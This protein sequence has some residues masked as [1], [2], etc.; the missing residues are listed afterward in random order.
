VRYNKLTERA[1]RVSARALALT[2]VVG[3]G[4]SMLLAVTLPTAA[5][6]SPV[7]ATTNSIHKACSAAVTANEAQCLALINASIPQV[8]YA[9]RG[10]SVP[11][12][13]P[14]SLLKAY[15]LAQ[16]ARKRGKG[17]VV[18]VVD[19]FNDPKAAHDLN[20]Y[21]S[22]FNLPKCTTSN[23]CFRKVNQQ[24]KAHPLPHNAGST[25]WDVEESLDIDMVS[26]VCPHCRIVLVETW[27]NNNI[28]LAKGVD[29][30]IKAGA[31]FI[32]NSYQ[33]GQSSSD[34]KLEKYYNHKGR[35][36]TAS[37]GDDG[38]GTG[39]PAASKYVTAVGGTSLYHGGGKRGWHESAW[40]GTGSGC[41][42]FEKRASWTHKRP[43]CSRRIV[44]DVSAVANPN[45]GVAVYDSYSAGGWGVVGG[46]SASSPIIAATYALAGKPGKHAYAAKYPYQHR[47]HLFDVRHGAN[48]SCSHR[49]LCHAVK[50][51]DGPTGLGTPNGYKA[52]K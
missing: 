17:H 5:S 49:Y 51:Y 3:L 10:E 25:G 39:Y 38:Y 6:A 13:G 21:R 12:Y 42:M 44:S 16:A 36:I 24:G 7:A 1:K 20:V 29:G 34:K 45:T 18:A 26:A 46:T 52:F 50:G 37:A 41:A 31:R 32:S 47:G 33:S 9:A 28:N 48:G 15:K 19:A 30:A 35:A 27:N 11:G 4:G 8:K 43:G 22:H 2:A 14:S 23:K 40:S